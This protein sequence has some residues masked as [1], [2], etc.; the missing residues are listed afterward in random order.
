SEGNII[1]KGDNVTL[2][3]WKNWKT[4][5]VSFKLEKETK[6]TLVVGIV[7]AKGGWGTADDLYLYQTKSDDKQDDSNQTPD[8]GNNKP[9][10]SNQTPDGGNNKPDDSN[11]TPDGGNNKPD[12]S[13]QTP[14]K[15]NN[16]PAETLT[17]GEV[18]ASAAK[19]SDDSNMYM[20][21]VIAMSGLGVSIAALMN[22]KKEQA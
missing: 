16:K 15:E 11:K 9:D 14:D 22:R 18:V 10:D 13:N 21:L 3:G 17:P 4:P 2:E 8:G 1:A 12:N 19:T 5:S 20:W 7:S 6:V